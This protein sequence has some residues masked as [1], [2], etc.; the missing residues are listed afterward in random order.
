MGSPK[1]EKGRG[2]D[3]NQ[4]SVT[5]TSPFYMAETETTQGQWVAL[6]GKSIQEQIETQDGP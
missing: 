5:L 1:E 6:T 2:R 3:E 4:V